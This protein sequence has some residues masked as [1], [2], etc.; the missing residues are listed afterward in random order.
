MLTSKP[1]RGNFYAISKRYIKNFGL[2]N[3]TADIKREILDTE[4]KDILDRLICDI[5]GIS[6]KMLEKYTVP[7]L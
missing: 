1:Y 7:L 6:Y 2:P 5:Y 3:L 4:T